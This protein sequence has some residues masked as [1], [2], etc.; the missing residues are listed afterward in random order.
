MCTCTCLKHGEH[1]AVISAV[2]FQFVTLQSTFP[3]G[4]QFDP[5]AFTVLY[6]SSYLVILQPL[7]KYV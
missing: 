7:I 2:I 3:S 6:G 1:R 5:M 4:L